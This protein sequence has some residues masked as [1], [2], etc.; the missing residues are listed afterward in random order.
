MSKLNFIVTSGDSRNLKTL[1]ARGR[2][3]VGSVP[4]LVEYQLGQFLCPVLSISECRLVTIVPSRPYSRTAPTPP[5][6][7]SS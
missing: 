6:R 4:V 3:G 5:V 2:K 1:I 7:L